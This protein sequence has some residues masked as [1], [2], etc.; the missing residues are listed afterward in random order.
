MKK[1]VE[2]SKNRWRSFSRG[3]Q[4]AIIVL[5]G[6]LICFRLALPYLVENYV[7]R[8]LDQLPDYDG[9]VGE[10]DIHLLRGA[11]SINHVDIVKTT[12]EVPVPFFAARKVD[13]SI[14]WRELFHRSVVGEIYID[15][16]KVNFVKG[17]TK[18]QSQVGID[19]SWV[20][21][22]EELFPFQ[23]NKFE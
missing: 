17:P 10:V 23:I 6:L 16:G 11:Y 2:K 9:R 21:I 12:G 18:E 22:V 20:G 5:I 15:Q 13:F 3:T 7:N 14:Q 1:L 8:K 4:I 19:K